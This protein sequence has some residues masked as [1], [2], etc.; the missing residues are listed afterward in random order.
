MT[1]QLHTCPTCDRITQLENDK[2]CVSCLELRRLEHIAKVQDQADRIFEGKTKLQA[3][4]VLCAVA[5][6]NCLAMHETWLYQYGVEAFGITRADYYNDYDEITE[7]AK[8]Y[9]IGDNWKSL[10][11]N[12]L[13]RLTAD[14]KREG[15]FNPTNTLMQDIEAGRVHSFHH[16]THQLRMIADLIEAI[17]QYLPPTGGRRIWEL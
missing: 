3:I 11:E 13:E 9:G 5:N 6:N 4:E 17:G 7:E 1:N 2:Y 8:E 10:T 12:H 14:L 15:V 16:Y